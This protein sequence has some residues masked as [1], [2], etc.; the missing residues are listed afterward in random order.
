MTVLV[1]RRLRRSPLKRM[2]KI[3]W[4]EIRSLDTSRKALRSF[5]L[6]VGAVIIAIAVFVLWR[7]GWNP[8]TVVYILMAAGGTLVL[9]GTTI[10]IL[11]RPVYSVWMA[12][13]VILGFFMTRVILTVVFYFV[14]TPIGL[15]MRAVGRDPLN[16][17][18]DADASTYWIEKSY[19]DETPARLE[20]FY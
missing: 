15:I 11:L 17:K 4:D 8:S 3:L 14:V 12:I 5:G 1:R 13:A 18:L 6:L 16:R 2:I 7:R 20:K 9:L 10:P 19:H